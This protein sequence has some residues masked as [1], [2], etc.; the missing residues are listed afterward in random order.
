MLVAAY[1]VVNCRMS[2]SGYPTVSGLVSWAVQDRG[3]LRASISAR[4]SVADGISMESN[5][6]LDE[7]LAFYLVSARV[8]TRPRLE[9]IPLSPSLIGSAIALRATIGSQ[10]ATGFGCSKIMSLATS[11]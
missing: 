9:R 10:L 6:R 3:R 4:P 11:H 2:T 1:I 5:S 7:P 8:L